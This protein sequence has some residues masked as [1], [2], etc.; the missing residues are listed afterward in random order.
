MNKTDTKIC[1]ACGRAMEWRRKWSRCW[2][3]VKFCSDACRKKGVSE[4][5]RRLET[6]ILMLLGKVSNGG[7]ICPSEVARAVACG[8][9]TAW[10]PLM[11]D[12]RRAARRLCEKGKIEITQNGSRVDPSRARGPIR[13]RRTD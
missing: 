8:D 11:E 1:Q 2:S 12:V 6:T 3:Q 4:S 7:S 13:L 9:E 5:D 10:R